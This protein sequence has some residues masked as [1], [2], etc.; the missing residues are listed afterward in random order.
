MVR[1]A[2]PNYRSR[3]VAREIRRKGENPIF[4]PTPPLESLRTILS[5]TATKDYWPE[6]IWFAEDTSD[7]R[8][9]ISLV[10]ISRAYFNARTKDEDPVYVRKS[11]L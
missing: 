2:S 10:D 6:E 11:Y 8:V 7:E 5:L 4:A 9:Q 1:A 3:L